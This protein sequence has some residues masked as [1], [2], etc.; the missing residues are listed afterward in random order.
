MII[1]KTYFKIIKKLSLPLSI[2]IVVFLALSIVFSYIGNSNNADTF[3]QSKTR[4]AFINEGEPS[5]LIQGLKD[6]LGGHSTYVD[7]ENR[8]DK[9]QDALF[10]R[11]AE[12]I[13]RIPEGFTKNFMTGKTVTVD[14]TVVSG[15]V[16]S[17][18]TDILI[19]KYFN[20]AR[21]YVNNS[22][23]I[24]QEE[25]VGQ[26]KKDLE[27][28]TEVILKSAGKNTAHTSA[29]VYFYNYMPYILINIIILGV[30]SIML[31]FNDIRLR[32]RNLCSPVSNISVNSQ[33][34]LGNIVF[35]VSC[36]AMLVI[37]SLL[38]Y[39]QDMFNLNSVYF[40]INSLVLTITILSMSFLIGVLIKSRNA[41][42]GISNVVSLGMC[43][44]TGVF[45]PQEMLSENVLAIAKFLPTYWYIRANKAIGALT[46]FNMEN[47]GPV[48]SYMLIE[49]GF[50][51]ALISVTLVLSKRK[52]LKGT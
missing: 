23:E 42:S 46:N 8:T 38:L 26:I 30:S 52:Q 19:N 32:R 14:K 33:I 15:S 3:T 25:L 39:R 28:E 37:L 41:Q 49:L 10:F 12:Y 5:A 27:L 43:F 35:S 50:A 48:V 22:K 17:I 34:L 44:L 40:C 13:L 2:Y 31:V 36:W 1:F 24:S 11:D 21:L 16:S 20:T 9:L 45:V 4:V 6:Y 47:I 29:I 51:V 18:Y 7:I